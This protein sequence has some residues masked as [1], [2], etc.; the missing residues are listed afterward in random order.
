MATSS[1]V[2]SIDL[3]TSG[4]KVALVSATGEVRGRAF[5]PV[6]LL[7]LPDGGAEQDPEAWW[8]AIRTA[9]REV[10]GMDLVPADQ[11]HAVSVTTQW[12]GT[13]AVDAD[14]APIGNA[15]IWMDSR[16]APY[17]RDLI[18]GS[19][20]IDGYDPRKLR[21]WIARTGGAP[22]R[23]GKD[24][25][26]HILYLRHERPDIYHRAALFLEPKDFINLR[27][28]GV[29]A[30]SFDSV[31]LHWITDNTDPAAVAYDDD[32]L[33]LAGLRRSQVPSLHAAV[34]VIGDVTEGAANEL[35]VSAGIP[36]IA[37]T[38][39]L[40]SAAIGAGTTEDLA[41]HLYLGTSS[42]L[43]C[44]VPFKKTDIIHS[45]GTLPAAIPGR[46]LAANEQ[47][48]AGKALDWL[49]DLFYPD[50]SD[51]AAVYAEMNRIAAAVPAGSGG[52][53]FT[54]WLYGERTPVEDSTLRGGFFN[55]G[56]D[57]GRDEMIRA[58]FEGVAYNTRWLLG[59]VEKFTGSRLDP[60]VMVGGGAQSALWCQIHADVLGRTIRQAEDPIMVNVRGA[61]LLAHVALGHLTW[62]DV[63]GLV[64]ME[65]SFTPDST[66]TAVYDRLYDAFRR[67]H[68]GTR[69]TYRR[70]NR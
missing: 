32:L 41:A 63:P 30:A 49:A 34:E 69:R 11:I 8:G 16:G 66:R 59:H 15:I 44:H 52:V 40:H 37:G 53:I 55:Q 23:S 25:L 18:G 68:K 57:T 4:P 14:G 10:I 48:T 43:T 2:L 35:G 62:A 13:V 12:S 45:I 20:R 51:H 56:L 54:P 70:L 1:H 28:T 19:I 61:G 46:F 39:D 58:V 64:P 50:R 21:R 5:A 47:E 3:G 67:I 9:C 31:A 7:L 42:W 24:S 36:V 60:I 26:A 29:A 33:E 27:L 6:D 38:P 22:S 17:I 65:A